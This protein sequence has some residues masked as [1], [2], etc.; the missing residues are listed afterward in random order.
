M[1]SG[2]L[3]I[4]K[5]V[6][7]E[8]I[9]LG[10]EEAGIHICTKRGW[11]AI[12]TVITPVIKELERRYPKLLLV[13]EE[14]AQAEHDLDTDAS[15]NTLVEQHMLAIETGQKEI[16]N[17]L[18]RNDDTLASYKE[19]FLRAFE[20]A[21]NRAEARQS[22]LIDEIRS[23]K[24]V[25]QASGQSRPLGNIPTIEPKPSLAE[26]YDQANSYQYDAMTWITANRPAVA[27]E[28]LSVARALTLLGIAREGEHAELMITMGFIEKSQAQVC[29]AENNLS[30]AT[31]YMAEAASYFT[32]AL[33]LRPQDL[34]ALNGMANVYAEGGDFDTAIEMG[35]AIMQADPNYGAA[36]WD[37]GLS[38]ENKLDLLTSE[39][40][41]DPDLLKSAIEV[42]EHLKVIM[43]QQPSAFRS[44]DLDHVLKRLDINLKRYNATTTIGGNSMTISLAEAQQEIYQKQQSFFSQFNAGSFV[45]A[46]ELTRNTITYIDNTLLLYPDDPYL[47]VVQGFC[48]KNEAMALRQLKHYSDAEKSLDKADQIFKALVKLN[49]G[50]FMAWHG[51]G[52]VEMLREN[53]Q[54]ALQDIDQAIKLHPNYQAAKRDREK[55]L[56]NLKH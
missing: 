17:V 54:T 45:T 14:M 56:Q 29:V 39:N 15:L 51:R 33:K 40:K 27:A 42:D 23:I 19:L 41:Y 52:N 35:R 31:H 53:W 22:I 50:D 16:L 9:A 10:I 6:L 46:L 4:A 20:E 37:L 1:A 25:V 5:K 48:Y 38:L 12:K 49:P 43:P 47:K 24:T 36:I 3:D 55:V 32:E 7:R 30:D 8:T 18:F 28:R 13:P 44:S 21:D 34:S 26:L 2:F 11:D